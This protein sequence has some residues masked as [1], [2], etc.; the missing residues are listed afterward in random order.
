MK[1]MKVNE[2][3]SHDVLECCY[4]YR[5][6]EHWNYDSIFI[7][8]DEFIT[9][10]PYI[11][12]VISDYKYFGAQKVTLEEWKKIEKLALTTD[13]FKQFFLQVINWIYN[14]PFKSDSFWIYG[15]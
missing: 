7:C 1:I 10:S 12:K 6:P 5:Y 3:V 11:E 13:N 15:V 4:D 14:D 9:L 2:L 8:Y